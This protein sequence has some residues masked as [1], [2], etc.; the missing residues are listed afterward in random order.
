MARGAGDP[1][2]FLMKLIFLTAGIF[3]GVMNSV[4]AEGVANFMILISVLFFIFD[5]LGKEKDD[6]SV[7]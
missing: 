2:V 6:A 3:T 4:G 5:M 7:S 1:N